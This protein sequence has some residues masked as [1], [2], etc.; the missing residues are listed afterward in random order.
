MAASTWA[1]VDSMT[2]GC[3]VETRETVW[4]ETPARR[5]TSAIETPRLRRRG[6]VLSGFSEVNNLHAFS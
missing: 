4:A 6:V 3:P 5:A 1:R 2:P